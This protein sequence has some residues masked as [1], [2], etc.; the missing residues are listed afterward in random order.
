[1]LLQL[2]PQIPNKVR[3]EPKADLLMEDLFP[4]F[5]LLAFQDVLKFF[6]LLHNNFSIPK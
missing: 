4:K 3:M 2:G 1:M 6:P 5:Y